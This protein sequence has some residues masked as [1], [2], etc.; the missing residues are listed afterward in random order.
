MHSG[1][2]LAPTDEVPVDVTRRPGQVHF[3]KEPTVVTTV[4][5]RHCDFHTEDAS[6]KRFPR[7]P[8]SADTVPTRGSEPEK[9]R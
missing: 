6:M 7:G 3:A 2:I 5:K 1:P 8:G 4:R 9:S